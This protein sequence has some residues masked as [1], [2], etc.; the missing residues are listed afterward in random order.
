MTTQ[1]IRFGTDIGSYVAA[2]RKLDLKGLGR[3]KSNNL[4][5]NQ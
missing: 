5:F 2:I 3:L 1:D 4:L